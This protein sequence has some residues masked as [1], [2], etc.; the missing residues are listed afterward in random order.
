VTATERVVPGLVSVIV[1]AVRNDTYAHQAVTSLL[2]DGYPTLEIVVIWDGPASLYE[3]A[4]EDEPSIRQI[5]NGAQLGI[6]E[7]LNRGIASSRGEFVARLDADDISYPGRL[8]TQVD[9]LR[10]HAS[11][12]VVA[13]AAR[14]IGASGELLGDYPPVGADVRREL[15]RR[16]PLVHS[17]LVM[18]RAALDEVGGYDA[19][20]FRVQDY[21][22]LLR[23]AREG[24][25]G[26]IDQPFVAYRLHAGQTSARAEH[27][28]RTIRII[29][30]DRRALCR[31]LGGSVAWQCV[32]DAGWI[33]A[34]WARY[35]GLRT[36]RVVTAVAAPAQA[37]ARD[38]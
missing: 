15:L 37:P 11:R 14:I 16:N 31:S 17:S 27:F 18:R 23:L 25:I 3:P 6:A 4:W 33:A 20:C 7:S 32:Q 29:A 30:A 22:L 35:R 19:R 13:T 28:W 34:Q 38:G 24:G 26:L 1:P 2:A 21:D 8:G 36:S 12:N 10:A 5:V 9:F